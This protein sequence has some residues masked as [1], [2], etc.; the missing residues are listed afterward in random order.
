[1]MPRHWPE[2]KARMWHYSVSEYKLISIISPYT[3]QNNFRCYWLNTISQQIT[4]SADRSRSALGWARS[5]IGFPLVQLELELRHGGHPTDKNKTIRFGVATSSYHPEAHN[6][7]T[8]EFSDFSL[9]S[10]RNISGNKQNQSVN[11]IWN[12]MFPFAVCTLLGYW[13]NQLMVA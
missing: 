10:S 6:H 1:M 2:L 9:C 7:V 4:L 11:R 8:T 3:Y 5:D 12:G 13:F